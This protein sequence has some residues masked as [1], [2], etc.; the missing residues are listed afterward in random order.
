[1]IS[2]RSCLVMLTFLVS[3]PA[4]AGQAKA[5][6]NVRDVHS[7]GS[8]GSLAD[9]DAL[10]AGYNV[11]SEATAT[12]AFIDLFDADNNTGEGTGHFA[13]N[14]PFPNNVIGADD[15]DFAIHATTTLSITAA[16]NYTFGVNSDDGSRLRIDTG[17][18][19]VTVINDNSTHAPSD[20]FGSVSFAT[21]GLYS[22]DFVYFERS[23]QAT[24]E[25]FAASGTFT[26]FDSSEFRLVGDTANGGIPTLD[27]VPEPTSAMLIGIGVLGLLGYTRRRGGLG[28]GHR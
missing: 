11:A 7:T 22:L 4:I 13:N 2:S 6:F 8:I 1:M 25:L 27:A 20:G 16:G 18:G 17:A 23:S 12:R 19:F 15:N 10:L 21:P 14:Q 26:D 3:L 9:A 24:V 5:D 28:L